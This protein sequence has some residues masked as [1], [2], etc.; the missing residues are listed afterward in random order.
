MVTSRYQ[1]NH[2]ER[3]R[4]KQDV[5]DFSSKQNTGY[6]TQSKI[7]SEVIELNIYSAILVNINYMYKKSNTLKSGYGK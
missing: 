4:K 1:D 6:P 5:R 3:F 2:G 7:Y